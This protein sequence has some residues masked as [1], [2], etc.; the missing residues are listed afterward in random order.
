MSEIPL[1]AGPPPAAAPPDAPA[2]D[3]WSHIDILNCVIGTNWLYEL[4]VD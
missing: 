3:F 4:A 2:F 1:E